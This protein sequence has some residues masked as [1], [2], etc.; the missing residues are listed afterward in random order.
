M[1]A[2]FQ[3]TRRMTIAGGFA[4]VAAAPLIA[5]VVLTPS[6]QHMQ[7][8]QCAPGEDGDLYTGHCVPY[9]VPNTPASGCPAGVSGAECGG[10]NQPVAQGPNTPA[11]D[12]PQQPE[13][14][15]ADVSTPGY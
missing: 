8:A 1:R 4:A 10:Q 9:L 6:S 14:Q 12:A 5:A 3:S 11:G 13:Q 2:I 15:L 7:L